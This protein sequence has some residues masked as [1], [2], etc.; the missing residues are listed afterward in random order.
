MHSVYIF[1]YNVQNFVLEIVPT[2]SEYAIR[3]DLFQSHIKSA[4]VVHVTFGGK[5]YFIHYLIAN[6]LLNSF[7]YGN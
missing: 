5:Y 7:Q 4:E 1:T 3:S 2:Q 6:R